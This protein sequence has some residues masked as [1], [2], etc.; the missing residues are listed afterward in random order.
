M[1]VF[2]LLCAIASAALGI[3]FNLW[4]LPLSAVFFFLSWVADRLSPGKP[5]GGQILA[6]GCATGIVRGLILLAVCV[7]I[8]L[9]VIFLI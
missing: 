8:T 3:F 1:S 9:A 2:M 5:T 7:L 4:L 6:S